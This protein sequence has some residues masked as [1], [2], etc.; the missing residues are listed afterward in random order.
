MNAGQFIADS[1]TTVSNF[2]SRKLSNTLTGKLLK[3]LSVLAPTPVKLMLV[4]KKTYKKQGRND[5]IDQVANDLFQN[6]VIFGEFITAVAK[7]EYR[8][9]DPLVL[10]KITTAFV[11]FVS[12]IDLIPD[13]IPVIGYMDDIFLMAWLIKTLDEELSA[14]EDWKYATDPSVVSDYAPS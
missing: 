3:R 11:Y 10:L 9:V 7:G 14:F 13:A 12:P 6:S 2:V 8:D 4:L 1:F 5:S